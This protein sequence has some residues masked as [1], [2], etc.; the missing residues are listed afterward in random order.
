MNIRASWPLLRRAAAAAVLLACGLVQA[1][2]PEKTITLVIPFAAGGPADAMGRV[3]A[4][5]MS[6]HLGQQVIVE[7]KPGAGG[8]LGIAAVSH[9]PADGYTLGMAGTGA[10]V[11]APFITRQ[12]LF[13]PLT[14]VAHLST[15]VRTPNLLVVKADS[16]W[17][18]VADL[19]QHAR[20]EPGVLNIASAGVGSSTHVV[21][22]LFQ[23]EAGIRM[24]HVPYK[25]AAPALQDLMGGQVDLFFAEVPAVMHLIAGGKLRALL[26]TDTRRLAGL[27]EV[28]TAAEAGLPALLAEGAYG[29]VAPPGLPADVA[30]RLVDAVNQALRSKEVM[31]K[32]AE[33]GGIAQPGN[34][35]SYRALLEAEQRR[36]APV[37]KAA[38][39]T[40]E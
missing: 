27:P 21:G 10:M 14:G 5:A 12:P 30:G 39:I 13:D 33:R 24:S 19:V 34:P 6:E 22:A 35:Q 32:F 16:P 25:G 40:P 9:A 28:P 4:G 37:I 36:W 38:G 11:Y 17:R 8:A 1:A 15:M 26:L 23:R 2:Y 18:S 7:N 3:L 29:L 31:Q 20:R